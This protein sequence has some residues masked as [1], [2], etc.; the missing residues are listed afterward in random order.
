MLSNMRFLQTA[1][2]IEVDKQYMKLSIQT[3]LDA[4]LARR[5]KR[6]F[7]KLNWPI[8]RLTKLVFFSARAMLN[9]YS[10]VTAQNLNC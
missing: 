5:Q 3:K 6:R 10:H 2:K 1:W 9:E 4:R 7:I 8:F